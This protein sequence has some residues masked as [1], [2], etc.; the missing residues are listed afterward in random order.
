MKKLTPFHHRSWL[1]LAIAASF[2]FFLSACGQ[3]DPAPEPDAASEVAEVEVEAEAPT[4]EPSPTATDEPTNTP[5]PTATNTPKPTA[6]NTPEPTAT[7][8]PEPTATNT[9]E[10]TATNTPEPTETAV[11]P[12]TAP[13][14]AE[15]QPTNPPEP[16]AD[17]SESESP[18]SITVYY[19][20]NPSEVLG[21]FPVKP[22]DGA[23]MYG[24][25]LFMRDSIGAMRGSIDGAKAGD[26]AACQ[27]YM[28]A[29]NNILYSG[30]FYEDIPPDWANIEVVY[31]VSF[32]YSLDRTRPAYLSCVNG[33]AVDDFNYS[34][35]LTAMNQVEQVLNPAI[36]EA[37]AKQ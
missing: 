34:L 24:Y 27:T 31:F 8:T 3:T 30:V 25:M 36:N 4:E 7:N 29:Y 21:V 18:D 33:A 23:A 37:A 22:F 13:P 5:Q 9:P 12:T 11:P 10:P 19:R 1:L 32:V 6:T 28:N 26:A 16:T 15:P 35:A 2:V 14:T 20:S 17:T